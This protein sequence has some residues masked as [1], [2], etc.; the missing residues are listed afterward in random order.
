[1][2]GPAT[3]PTH[4]MQSPRITSAPYCARRGISLLGRGSGPG[5][6]GPNAGF[7]PVCFKPV[8]FKPGRFKPGRF[9]LGRDWS[10][11][12]A[13]VRVGNRCTDEWREGEATRALRRRV[14]GLAA[15]VIPR[16]TRRAYGAQGEATLALRRTSGVI[17]SSGTPNTCPPR[18]RSVYK[19]AFT[20]YKQRA[21]AACK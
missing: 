4:A 17:L 6:S 18:T 15:H 19:Q 13:L 2:R 12:A 3:T 11:A 9:K 10:K 20:V 21:Q 16:V 14:P 5:H 7:K 8:R 1:M